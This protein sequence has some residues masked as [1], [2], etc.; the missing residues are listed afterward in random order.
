[1]KG[2][3]CYYSGSGN[4]KLASEYIAEKLKNADFSTCNIVR[5][6]IPDLSKYDIVGFATFTDFGD[7]PK[8]FYSF[9]DKMHLYLILMEWFQEKR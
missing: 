9:F 2:I 1:M 5:N 6:E 4:T 8:Y 7:V 3:I